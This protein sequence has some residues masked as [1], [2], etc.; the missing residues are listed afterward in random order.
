MGGP[1]PAGGR[2]L[3][4]SCQAGILGISLGKPSCLVMYLVKTQLSTE[5]ST[6]NPTVSKQ[7][8]THNPTVSAELSS[9]GLTVS[10]EL[11][12]DNPTV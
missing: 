4:F 9:N 3:D 7:L 2:S 6:N 1:N 11:S 12:S 5:L 8:S 10:I